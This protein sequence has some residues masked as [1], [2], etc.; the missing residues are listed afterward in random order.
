MRDGRQLAMGTGYD[1]LSPR[2]HTYSATGQALQNRLI[3]RRAMERFGFAPYDREW[4]H[5]EHRGAGDTPRDIT[6]GCAGGA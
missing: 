3:L 4:W 1:D 5:F 6:L 2:A